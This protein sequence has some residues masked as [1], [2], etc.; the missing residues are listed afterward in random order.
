MTSSVVFF[1]SFFFLRIASVEVEDNFDIYYIMFL[2][3][4][5]IDD[6]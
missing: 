2:F 6:F 3:Y 5:I 1:F 4:P